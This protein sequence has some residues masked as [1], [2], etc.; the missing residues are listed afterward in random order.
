MKKYIETPA[1]LAADSTTATVRATDVAEKILFTHQGAVDAINSIIRHPRSLAR[2]TGQWR[3]PKKDLPGV[4]DWGP[5]QIAL[6]RHRVGPRAK[7]RVRGYGEL[8]EPVYL[9]S[10]RIT[11]P[12]GVDVPRAIAE[13]W[14]RALVDNHLVGAIHEISTGSAPTFVWMVD[15]EYRPVHSPVSLFAGFSEAA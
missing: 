15:R 1:A 12:T 10:A 13:G 14:I 3:P 6:T 4:I 11:D 7:A 9:I 5:L 2:P 8:R